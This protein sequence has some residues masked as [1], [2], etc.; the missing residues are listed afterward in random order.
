MAPLVKITKKFVYKRY[1]YKIR[2]HHVNDLFRHNQGCICNL[3]N[4]MVVVMGGGGGTCGG[5]NGHWERNL[6]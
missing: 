5:L 3:H 1:L 2:K 4:T 6:N